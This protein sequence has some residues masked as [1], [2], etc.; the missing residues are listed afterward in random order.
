LAMML[1]KVPP[2]VEKPTVS[3]SFDREKF[4]LIISSWYCGIPFSR[5]PQCH[6]KDSPGKKTVKSLSFGREGKA[7]WSRKFPWGWK[8]IDKLSD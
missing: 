7:D 6:Y 5:G 8:G 3:A 4:M 1:V 2:V